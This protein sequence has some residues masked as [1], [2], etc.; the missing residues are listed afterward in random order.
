MPEVA[1]FAEVNKEP[2]RRRLRPRPN[3]GTSG[4]SLTV[5]AASIGRALSG[6]TGRTP[7]SVGPGRRHPL[8]GD[9]I[10]S[11]HSHG[12]HQTAA[13][14]MARVAHAVPPPARTAAGRPAPGD[15]WRGD[16][17]VYADRRNEPCVVPGP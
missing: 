16:A 12:G 2:Q 7:T 3:S 15:E 6:R 13:L 8:S 10:Q 14:R 17:T 4:Y 9:L 5:P 11:L 1:A